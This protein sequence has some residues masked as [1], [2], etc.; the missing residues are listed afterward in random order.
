MPRV[1]PL[2][3]SAVIWATAVSTAVAGMPIAICPCASR[4]AARA[5]SAVPKAPCCCCAGDTTAVE[6]QKHDAAPSSCC[7]PKAATD[8]T[9]NSSPI[10]VDQRTSGAKLEASQCQKSLAPSKVV[11]SADPVGKSATVPTLVYVFVCP[12]Y[13]TT[14]DRSDRD[15]IAGVH[16][17]PVDL[18]TSLQRLTI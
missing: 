7:S 13:L 11:A 3:L 8:L 14:A 18:A 6:D 5:D 1:R 15:S 17:P 12:A 16:A 4:V 10:T 9:S 2:L